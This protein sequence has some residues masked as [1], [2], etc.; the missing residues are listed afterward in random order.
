MVPEVVFPMIRTALAEDHT[1]LRA[2]LRQFLESRPGITFAGEA[3]DGQQAIQL[4]REVQPDVILLDIAM[5]GTDGLDA[6]A[7]IRDLGLP[8]RVIV[9]SV[10]GEAPT[11]RLAMESGADGYVLK[12]ELN[13]ELVAAIVAVHGGERYLS[14]G[15][16]DAANWPLPPAR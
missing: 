13:H 4:V 8:T 15:V 10:Y 1:H 9:I 16:R 11:V 14:S 3:A 12:T 6:L 2:A 5:P 7:Q